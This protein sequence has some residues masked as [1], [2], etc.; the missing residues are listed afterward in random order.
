MPEAATYINQLDPLQ[1]VPG[2][3]QKQGDD[4]IRLTKGVLKNTFPA[5]TG[6]VI[7]THTELNKL[8]GVTGSILT[9]A[10]P[11]A[12]GSMVLID[13]RTVTSVAQIDFVHGVG[14]VVIDGTYDE[15]ILA[16]QGVSPATTASEIWLHLSVDGG[17]TF[18]ASASAASGHVQASLTAGA[19]YTNTNRHPITAGLSVSSGNS[20]NGRIDITR[21]GGTANAQA[22]V[23][24]QLVWS[25]GAI[26]ARAEGGDVLA[27]SP[28]HFNAIRIQ[29]NP[30]NFAAQGV[31]K[32]FGRK[33]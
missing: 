11:A 8:A 31:I 25:G 15:Y 24:S 23:F 4:H 20:V 5:I 28:S 3:S 12:A 9:S 7:A 2:E 10:S 6:P 19:A 26:S 27:S 17:T 33:A 21:S 13:S 16:L 1:P 18:P 22:A 32:L 30:S 14:G 29:F